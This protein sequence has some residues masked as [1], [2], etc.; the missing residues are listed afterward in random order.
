[1]IIKTTNIGFEKFPEDFYACCPLIPYSRG[2]R[3]E[4]MVFDDAWL[5]GDDAVE[6]AVPSPS[7]MHDKITAERHK[8]ISDKINEIL[9]QLPL[10]ELK[11][12]YGDL[13]G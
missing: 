5:C 7:T 2:K 12:K 10:D 9:E 13:I 6:C 8:E 3:A 4:V 11:E 1:M